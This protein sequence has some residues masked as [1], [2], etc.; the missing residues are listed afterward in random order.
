M[1]RKHTQPVKVF[2]FKQFNNI[3]V[4]SSWMIGITCLII[5]SSIFI[6]PEKNNFELYT[7][8]LDEFSFTETKDEPEEILCTSDFSHEPPQDEIMGHRN[9][10]TYQDLSS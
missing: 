8:H 4:D 10:K 1:K 6:I 9:I 5:N 2:S 7:D 3:D